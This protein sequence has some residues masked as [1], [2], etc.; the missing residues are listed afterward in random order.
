MAENTISELKFD[1]LLR[2][3]DTA[4]VLS[5]RLSEWCGK[6]PALE[7]DMALTNTALDLL[8]QARLWLEYAGQS[9][10]AGRDEDALAFRRGERAFRNLLLAELPNGGYAGTL[11]RQFYF[12]A[13]HHL[14]LQALQDSTDAQV[15]AI[16]E[17]SAKE[18]AYHLRR[19]SDLVVRLGD[20]TERSHALMQQAAERLWPYTGEM[21]ASDAVDA[22]MVETGVGFDPAGLRQPW[23]AYVAQVFETASLRLP[24]AEAWMHDGG[25]RGVHTEH[26][27][28][29]LAE[30]QYLQRAYPDAQ[31]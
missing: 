7:E 26:L 14:A 20:G 2:W 21:F 16:A 31:W 11:M 19:S 17:K 24:P 6:G 5:Q 1:Y 30:M 8:G 27:G 29:L 4:L 18:A 13:W 28:F 15:A 10:G 25:K 23:L 3:G 22:A 9:E 12:D